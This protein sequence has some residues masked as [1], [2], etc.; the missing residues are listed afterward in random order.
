MSIRTFTGT[1]AP[2]MYPPD[3]HPGYWRFPEGQDIY[4]GIIQDIREEKAYPGKPGTNLVIQ[5]VNGPYHGRINL[6]THTTPMAELSRVIGELGAL[7]QGK[8]AM[9]R[10]PLAKGK[11]IAFRLDQF[12]SPDGKWHP[13]L[14]FGAVIPQIIPLA[15]GL[16]FGWSRPELLPPLLFAAT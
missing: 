8:P 10:L 2:S 4:T 14:R 1:E 6:N 7:E 5:V 9:D 15:P 16:N 12:M 11:A 13:V 3:F